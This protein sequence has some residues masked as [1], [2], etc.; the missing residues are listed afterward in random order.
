MRAQFW[1]SAPP[2]QSPSTFDSEDAL[3]QLS[4]YD[5]V[6]LMDD[7]LSMGGA[8]WDQV[9]NMFPSTTTGADNLH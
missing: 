3:E 1:K 7:S 9:G 6:I 5:V 8:Y 4:D 2:T